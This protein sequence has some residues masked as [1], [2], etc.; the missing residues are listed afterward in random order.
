MLL[1][2]EALEDNTIDEAALQRKYMKKLHTSVIAFFRHTKSAQQ[3]TNIQIQKITNLI[4][5]NSED[6]KTTLNRFQSN[7]IK[8]FL[9]NLQNVL[10]IVRFHIVLILYAI[11]VIEKD[12]ENHGL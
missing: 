3:Q 8:V 2:Q 5:S 11:T 6:P 12:L 4:V 7:Y 10:Y 1:I 9:F